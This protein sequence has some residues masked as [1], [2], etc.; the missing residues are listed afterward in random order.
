VQVQGG[1]QNLYVYGERGPALTPALWD[2]LAARRSRA[3]ATRMPR[4]D[5]AEECEEEKQAGGGGGVGA[6][7]DTVPVERRT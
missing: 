7:P 4:L 5:E 3:A 2:G 6:A 1:F